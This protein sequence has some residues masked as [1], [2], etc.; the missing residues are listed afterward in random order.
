LATARQFQ[1][2]VVYR[3]KTTAEDAEAHGAG[4]RGLGIE[5]D[6]LYRID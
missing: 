3:V 2:A 5:R 6:G 1:M 4:S